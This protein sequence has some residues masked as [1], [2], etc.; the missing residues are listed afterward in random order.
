[1]AVYGARK[2][3]GKIHDGIQL[4][5]AL[6]AHRTIGDVLEVLVDR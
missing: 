5:H 3:D 1:M 2:L 6:E 4:R